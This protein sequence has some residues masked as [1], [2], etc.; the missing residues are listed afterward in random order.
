M[1]VKIR[2][3]LAWAMGIRQL[4]PKGTL[5][6]VTQ[7]D[8]QCCFLESWIRRTDNGKRNRRY[9]KI[10]L[11][12]HSIPLLYILTSKQTIFCLSLTLTQNPMYSPLVYYFEKYITSDTRYKRYYTLS[13]RTLARDSY[14]RH[15]EFFLKY[16]YSNLGFE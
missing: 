14:L 10:D 15:I 11:N 1:N 3:F 16:F 5:Y 9:E 8:R 4:H 2:K 12:W 7:L 13:S 6:D